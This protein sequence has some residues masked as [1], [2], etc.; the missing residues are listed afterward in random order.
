M[1]L[2]GDACHAVVPFYG[3]GMNAAFED[4]LVLNECMER[5][6]PDWGRAFRIY[7]TARKADVDTL[8]DMAIG[9]FVEM[10]DHTGSRTFR[11][12]KKKERI[13]HALFPKWF[14][15]LYT[16]ATFT[17]M[18]YTE[19]VARAKKQDRIV[20]WITLALVLMAVI[21]T[22]LFLFVPDSAMRTNG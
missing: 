21:V 12:K 7:Y 4:V 11:F 8:A 2:L 20:Y 18:P 15:P 19:A 9:N 3:Q 22:A 17:R 1:V 10:R 16:M 13:L 5:F 6:K 14:I